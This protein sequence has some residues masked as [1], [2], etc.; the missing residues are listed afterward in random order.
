MLVKRLVETMPRLLAVAVSFSI[1][2]A[3]QDELELT[4]E[5][6]PT[7]NVIFIHPDGTALNH[8]NAARL[9]WEGPDGLLAWDK[10][11]EIAVYRGHMSDQ[12]TATSNAG[13]TAHAFGVKVQGPD[14][15][16][17]DRGRSI[18]ALSGF[19]GSILREAASAGHP[20]GVVNDGDINGEPGTGAFLAE[21]ANRNQVNDQALQILGGRPGFD[22]GTPAD[23]I[24]GEPDPVVVLGGG[25]RFFLPK[26][27]DQCTDAPTLDIPRLD[28]FLHLD[29]IN[30]RRP[31][32]RD[33]R[34]LLQEAAQD[35][36]VVIRTRSEFDALWEKL[37]RDSDY[38]P[39]VLGLFAADDIFNDDQEEKLIAKGLVRGSADPL[40]PEGEKAGRIVGWGAKH[41]DLKRPY[42]YDP[43]TVAELSQLA[44]LILDRRSRLVEKKPF[45]VVIEVESSDNFSN[46]NNAIGALRALKRA[47]EVIQVARAFEQGEGIW[48]AAREPSTDPDTLIVT[49]ADSDGSGLQV[50]ALRTVANDTPSN[51]IACKDKPNPPVDEDEPDP[52]P[53]SVCRESGNITTFTVVNPNASS[54]ATEVEVD[55]IEGRR[56]APFLAGPDALLKFRP[57]PD[58]DQSGL[59]SAGGGSVPAEALPFA[60]TWASV[61]DLAGG[62]LARAQG[63]NAE[64]LREE[65]YTGFDN[66][67]VYRLMYVTLFGNLL[68]S[69][70]GQPA[71]DRPLRFIPDP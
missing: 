57:F 3:A 17:T 36:W 43:P 26:G 66:T 46:N 62:I 63:L 19:P 22:G 16:G 68:P 30:G 67:D 15:Y 61:D 8:W 39:K 48:N 70:I 18:L 60:I 54:V 27:T 58:Q 21:T 69:A 42:S 53:R 20:V 1:T 49:A 28:C 44:L 34:N 35:D 12:L 59:G 33:G 4:S 32:R 38:A 52:N 37:R 24:D 11:P 6:F 41:N 13:A 25:E 65:F 50:M 9:Y 2:A 47:D 31:A 10:L 40:P 5:Q 45:A 23:I 64:L 29:P 14:S 71:Q 51:P 56:T 55:G 7:G